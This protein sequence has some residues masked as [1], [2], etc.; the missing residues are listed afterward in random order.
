MQT[1][2]SYSLA[3]VLLATNW[4]DGLINDEAYV[5]SLVQLGISEYE[6]RKS[7]AT[8]RKERNHQVNN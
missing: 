6:A 7:L 3:H 4:R 8:L 5:R 2:T 1:V